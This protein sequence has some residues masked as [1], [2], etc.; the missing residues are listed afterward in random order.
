LLLTPTI[1]ELR[2]LNFPHRSVTFAIEISMAFE[3]LNVK[4]VFSFTMT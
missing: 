1:L 4:E 2:P 3:L